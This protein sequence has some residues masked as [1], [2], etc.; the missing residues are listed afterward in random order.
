MVFIFRESSPSV[1]V[2]S[3]QNI[4]QA[5]RERLKEQ[6]R[7]E[8]ERVSEWFSAWNVLSVRGWGLYIELIPCHV[9]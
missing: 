3:S 7:L 4:D 9:K 1:P 5:E 2:S 8:R 6:Q